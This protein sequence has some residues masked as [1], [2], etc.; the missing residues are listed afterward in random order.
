MP[1]LLLVLLCCRYLKQ[2][3]QC[4]QEF[5]DA[6][7][8]GGFTRILHTGHPDDLMDEIPTFV[9]KTLEEEGADQ[10]EYPPLNRPYSYLQWLQETD[11]P[12][13]Y[14]LWCETDEIFLRPMPNLIGE[15][16]RIVSYKSFFMDAAQVSVSPT[17]HSHVGR[18]GFCCAL[19]EAARIGGMRLGC[20][21]VQRCEHSW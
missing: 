11:I 13:E 20:R 5:G 14:V 15:D 1:L 17:S 7:E 9:A 4:E 12:E 19:F 21:T 16:N 8:M 3:A 10:E 6:C 18:L 2:K